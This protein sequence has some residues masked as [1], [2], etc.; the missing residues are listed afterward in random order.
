V[1]WVGGWSRWVD[2]GKRGMT[3]GKVACWRMLLV[4]EVG[5]EVKVEV[6]EGILRG[7]GRRGEPLA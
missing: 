6:E 1:V 4:K 5:E 2:D 3:G 7:Q